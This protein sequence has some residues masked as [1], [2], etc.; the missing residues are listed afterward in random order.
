MENEIWKD[1]YGYEGYYIISNLGRIRSVDRVI[2]GGRW[3]FE[4]RKGHDIKHKIDK[5]EGRP[6]VKLHLDGIRKLR[7]LAVIL[8]ESFVC[9]RPIGMV[10]CH[11]DGN[12]MNNDL[13]NLRWDTPKGNSADAIKHGTQVRGETSGSSKLKECEVETIRKLL[14]NNIPP[15]KISL[16]FKVDIHCIYEIRDNKTWKHLQNIPN[17]VKLKRFNIGEDSPSSKLREKEVIE[18]K[19]LLREG[20]MTQKDIAKIFNIDKRVVNS[21]YKN[22]SWNHI[23]LTSNNQ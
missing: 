20:N 21:I 17:E 7:Q 9:P 19:R 15:K 16:M 14:M 10:A 23:Q 8:L 4:H 18:I 5:R 3:G 1:V 11:N 13:S 2:N 6:M 22:R 12:P